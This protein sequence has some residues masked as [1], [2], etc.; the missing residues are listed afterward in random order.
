MCIINHRPLLAHKKIA[1][2]ADSV[3]MLAIPAGV[4][5]DA[6]ELREDLSSGPSFAYSLPMH[7][8]R[9][10]RDRVA[11]LPPCRLYGA[12]IYIRAPPLGPGRALTL[13]CGWN[14]AGLRRGLRVERGH[15]HGHRAGVPAVRNGAHPKVHRGGLYGQ[16]HA[17]LPHQGQE[18][19]LG[20]Y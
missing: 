6:L 2:C 4:V 14:N 16:H 15:L 5:V 13:P 11:S 7:P 20:K 10:R 17:L 19:L 18:D 12:A 1:A 9:T 8:V 3:V